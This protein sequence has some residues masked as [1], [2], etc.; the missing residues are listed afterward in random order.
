MSDAKRGRVRAE[1]AWL[2]AL[3]EPAATLHWSLAEWQRVVRLARRL[4]LLARLA[5]SVEAAG[6]MPNVPAPARRH[7][8]AESRLSQ[9]RTDAM[10]WLL[11]RV[12]ATLAGGGYPCVLLKGAAYVGQ[13]LPIAAGRLPADV[14]VLVPREHLPAAQAALRAAGWQELGL[15][16]HDSRYYREWSHEVPPMHHP[17]HRIELDLHHNILPPVARMRVDADRLLAYL[18]PSQWPAWQVLQPADQV[19]HSAA[20][21]FQDPELRDRLRDLVD[22]DGLMRHFGNQSDFWTT[23]P[24]RARELGLA[25]PLSLAVHFCTEWLETPVPQNARAEIAVAGPGRGQR[26]WLLPALASLLRPTEPDRPAPWH[27]PLA[28]GLVAARHHRD[29]MPLR[30]LV[31]H[32]WHKLRR[33]PAPPAEAAVGPAAHGAG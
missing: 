27:Q 25:T 10:R 11:E 15:D 29:R 6:L 8:L 32:L 30:L 23:L 5:A 9:A 28:A 24:R 21:L 7:L 33:P 3:R 19:L 17:L 22:L 26:A 14:D 1:L 13:G 12:G 16:E 31:P 20:H 4:R 18:Q 2:Q